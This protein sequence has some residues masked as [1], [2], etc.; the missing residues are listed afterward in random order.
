LHNDGNRIKIAKPGKYYKKG[1]EKG[2]FKPLCIGKD[3]KSQENNEG[4]E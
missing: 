2:F 3:H 1:E 4:Y